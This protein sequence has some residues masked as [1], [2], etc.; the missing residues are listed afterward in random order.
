M[1][2]DYGLSE[3]H[4]VA[5]SSKLDQTRS[6]A[7]FFKTSDPRF[8]KNVR[9][10]FAYALTKPTDTSRAIGPISPL[11]W[12]YFPGGKR[13]DR[14]WD[15]ATERLLS[16]IPGQALNIVLTT[17]PQFI[18]QAEGIEKELESFGEFAFEQC[19][20]AEA[21]KDKALCENTRISITLKITIVPDVTSFDMLL[22]GQATPPDPDQYAL[23]HSS[24]QTT[25][26]TNYK[27]TRIDKLLEDGRTKQSKNERI[28]VYQEFQQFFLEDV[29][30]LFISHLP[31]YTIERTR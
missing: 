19:Q 13:Y 8:D 18:S 14:D 11:S 22:T 27:N 28:E 21:V 15:R 26:I 3:W 30:A 12:A 24:N 20:T 1:S 6:L 4:N 17:T 29:P 23:W 2:Q 31:V 5:V 9:Q 7:L 10:A 16:A 25:N